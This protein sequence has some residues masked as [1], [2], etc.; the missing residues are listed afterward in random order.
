HRA[1][2]KNRSA[3]SR[4]G[5]VKSFGNIAKPAGTV[6]DPPSH[7]LVC[8]AIQRGAPAVITA[9]YGANDV[10]IDAVIQYSIT[11]TSSASLLKRRSTSPS[12][13]LQRWKNCTSHAA[14]PAGESASPTASSRGRVPW[15][16]AY[17][18]SAFWNS[19]IASR[20]L[21]SACV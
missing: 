19:A 12:Q 10:P 13:S 9:W 3:H 15:I 8:S 20:Y 7:C 6:L 11:L 16:S 18:P 4:G 1:T 21:R 2:L 17:A 14:S 5:C